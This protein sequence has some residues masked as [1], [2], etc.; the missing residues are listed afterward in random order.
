MDDALKGF[1]EHWFAGLV[2]GLAEVGEG[3]RDTILRACGRACAESYTAQVFREAWRET[4]DLDRFLVRLAERF[5]GATYERDG[6]H[7]IRVTYMHC[8]CDLVRLGLV[9]SPLLCACSAY[10]LAENLQRALGR[11]VSVELESSILTGAS[12]CRLRAVLEEGATP[13]R[14]E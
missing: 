2:A 9:R 13:G 7:A 4:D 10:N 8:G 11:P 3:A 14:A 1:M 6:S 12:C 5:A